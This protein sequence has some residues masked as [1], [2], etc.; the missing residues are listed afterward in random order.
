MP[1]WVTID[2][3]RRKRD[4]LG[5]YNTELSADQQVEKTETSGYLAKKYRVTSFNR[6]DAAQEIRAQDAEDGD[7]D[8]LHRNFNKARV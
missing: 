3:G 1:W 7:I 8:S 5:P 2:T 6:T 4:L